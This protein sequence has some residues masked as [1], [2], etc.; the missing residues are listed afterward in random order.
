M[1]KILYVDDTKKIRR[2]IADKIRKYGFEVMEAGN[3]KDALECYKEDMPD[4][5]FMD[6]LMPV[7]DGLEATKKILEINQKA[8]IV[9]M[10][11]LLNMDIDIRESII[12]DVFE[13]GAVNYIDKPIFNKD[14]LKM[15]RKYRPNFI[16]MT[17]KYGLKGLFE[18]ILN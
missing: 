16:K 2:E 9:S 13:T 6:M 3:G 11:S 12:E 5:V 10:I 1:T 18:I 8:R 17:L 15:I 4:I 7:M 14:L